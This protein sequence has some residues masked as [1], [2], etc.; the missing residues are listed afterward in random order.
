MSIL[1]K[2]R[3]ALRSPDATLTDLHEALAAV[4]TDALQ[5]DVVRA[6]RVRAGLLLD[7]SEKQLDVAEATLTTAIRERDRGIVAKAELSKRIAEKEV[8][9]AAAVLDAERDAVEREAEAVKT[10]LTDEWLQLQ[11][12]SVKILT[13]L[14][15]AEKAV[16][17]H[18]GRRIKAGRTDL[19]AS[20]ET[21]AFAAPVGQYAPLHSIL[22]TT[23]LKAIG[24]AAGWPAKKLS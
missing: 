7:G 22:E 8:S 23:S 10:I 9:D 17:N 16:E 2:I 24:P 21:R 3:K 1:D 4:D 5:A 20:V 14:A 19:V 12:K 18:N 15:A 13:R 6:E 11:A